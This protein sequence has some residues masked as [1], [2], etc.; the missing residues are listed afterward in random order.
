[1]R[2]GTGAGREYAEIRGGR[3][4]A[5]GRLRWRSTGRADRTF[6]GDGSTTATAAAGTVDARLDAEEMVLAIHWAPAVG[7]AGR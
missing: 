7:E 1:M 2:P 5:N 4:G 3:V 6:A